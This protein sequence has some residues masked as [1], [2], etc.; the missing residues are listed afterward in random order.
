MNKFVNIAILVLLAVFI[1]FR[2]NVACSELSKHQEGE[3]PT[4]LAEEIFEL[5]AVFHTTRF[6]AQQP[7]VSADLQL[8]NE[9]FELTIFD[10]RQNTIKVLSGQW[11]V[12]NLTA[13]R[14]TTEDNL[15]FQY[16]IEG[17]ELHLTEYGAPG[18][19]PEQF[20]KS[21]PD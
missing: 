21:Q 19:V 14:L 20:Q 10:T 12:P 7:D 13:I 17:D 16:T 18:V 11:D 6:S 3:Q 4:T 1:S 2:I 8:V 5:P 9:E 15:V